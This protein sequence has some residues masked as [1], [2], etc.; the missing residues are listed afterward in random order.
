VTALPSDDLRRLAG[1]GLSDAAIAAALGKSARTILR[2]RQRLGIPSSWAPARAECGTASGYAAGCRCAP[3]KAA[4]VAATRDRRQACNRITPN[5]RAGA[6][7]TPQDDAYLLRGPGTL[8]ERA[9]RLGRTYVA[10]EARL[11]I[12]RRQGGRRR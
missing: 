6:P 9:R 10:C 1:A 5:V 4:N 8:L 2:W 12:L 7:W 3:C 11:V